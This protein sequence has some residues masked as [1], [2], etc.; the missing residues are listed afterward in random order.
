VPR[1]SCT[2]YTTTEEIPMGE[3]VLAGMFFLNERPI[4]I[5]FDCRASHDFMSSMCAKKTKLS[6]VALGTPY[7]ISTP[8]G[9]VDVDRLVHRVHLTWSGEYLKLT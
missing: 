4:I 5:L 8:R 7:V 2:N 6:R 1:S 3:E 9:R